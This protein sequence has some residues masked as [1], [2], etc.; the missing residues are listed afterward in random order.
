MAEAAEATPEPVE[1]SDMGLE[2][3]VAEEVMTTGTRG[4]RTKWSLHCIVVDKHKEQRMT[5]SQ[6]MSFRKCRHVSS[7]AQTWPKQHEK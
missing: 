3:L 5:L 1:V 7:M 2:D 6:N 4:L